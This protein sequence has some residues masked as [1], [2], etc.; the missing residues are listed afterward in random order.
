MVN[1]PK[2]RGKIAECGY[3]NTS[4]SKALNINRNTLSHYMKNPDSIPYGVL[5]DM[6]RLLCDD[7]EE[8]ARIFFA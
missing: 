3:N 2:L 6:A 4:F 1:I 8:V 5:I 7:N